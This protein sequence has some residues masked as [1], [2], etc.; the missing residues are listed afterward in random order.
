M[1]LNFILWFSFIDLMWFWLKICVVLYYVCCLNVFLFIYYIV[2][3]N[4]KFWCV[5]L[6]VYYMYMFIIYILKLNYFK[7]CLYIYV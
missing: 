4:L 6:I 5:K 7:I 2:I 1:I 3:N